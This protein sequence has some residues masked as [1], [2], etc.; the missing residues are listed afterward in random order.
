MLSYFLYELFFYFFWKEFSQKMKCY[1]RIFGNLLVQDLCERIN[2]IRNMKFKKKHIHNIQILHHILKQQE[3]DMI[4]V[5][6]M[7]CWHQT[8]FTILDII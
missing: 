1:G 5:Y 7:S 4:T 3:Q 6:V 2:S 8:D